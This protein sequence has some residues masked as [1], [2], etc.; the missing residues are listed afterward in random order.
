MWWSVDYTLKKIKTAPVGV[1]AQDFTDFICIAHTQQVNFVK[2]RIKK[3]RNRD[4]KSAE[5]DETPNQVC[6][7]I[8]EIVL[9]PVKQVRHV[10]S[11]RFGEV[12]F[13]FQFLL[14]LTQN[15]DQITTIPDAL[16][17]NT[18]TSYNMYPDVVVS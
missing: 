2:K 10:F 8:N 11:Y 15:S 12:C 6:K 7:I 13:E 1:V 3:V 17:T 14:K 4:H 18:K 16:C 9:Q 5:S